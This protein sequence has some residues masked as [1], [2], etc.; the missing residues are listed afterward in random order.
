MESSTFPTELSFYNYKLLSNLIAFSFILLSFHPPKLFLHSIVLIILIT[1]FIIQPIIYR[2]KYPA[3]IH[4]QVAGLAITIGVKMLIWLK[5]SIGCSDD[6]FQPFFYT[7]FYWRKNVTSGKKD[8]F[9][10]TIAQIIKNILGR[11]L[12]L[13]IKQLIVEG[14]FKLLDPYSNINEIP[15]TPYFFRI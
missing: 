11:I 6:D 1:C 2:G 9:Q 8:E 7:L 13:F 5:N 3:N 15:S 10:P 14:C 4:M 12:R